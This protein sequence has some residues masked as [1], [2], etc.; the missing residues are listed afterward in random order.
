MNVLNDNKQTPIAF[1]NESML[2]LLDLKEAVATY[3]G[4]AFTTKL[5]PGYDNNRFLVRFQKK[6]STD[7]DQLEFK[8]NSLEKPHGNVR[9]QNKGV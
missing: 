8:Y 9:L 7:D 5:P 1:G 3:S 6:Q 4:R 2:T